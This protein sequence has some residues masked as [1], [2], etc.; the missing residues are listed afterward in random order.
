MIL[1]L[2]GRRS[3]SKVAVLYGAVAADAGPDEQD[4]L[5]EVETVSRGL[6]GLGYAP[7]AIPI[8]LDLEA[9][10]Q[11]LMH[12][13]PAFVFN[14]VESIEGQ[15]RLIHLAPALL[16]SLGLPHT[17]GSGDAAYVT[18]NKPLAKRLLAAAGISTPAWTA[19]GRLPDFP[20]PYI[21]KSVWEHASIGIEDGSVTSDPARLPGLLR[22]RQRRY[23]GEWFVE[24]YVEGREFNLSLLAGPDGVELLPPAE[25]CFVDYPPGKPRIV[26]YAAKWDAASFEYHATQRRFDFA[27]EE[28]TL[29]DNLTAT[30]KAC[31]RLFDLNGYARV[32]C[33][34][35]A[36][37]RV[38]VLEINMN[39]CISPDA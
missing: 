31:W 15:G 32:D 18:S 9:A 3:A 38:Q 5:T 6:A 23:G 10:R 21:V 14:L 13:R 33:R 22:K 11:R 7:V 28:R 26:N 34:V 1:P 36:A 12:L 17:G 37:G 20:G 27:P 35:D 39:P 4:V 25:M 30:A 19:P 16:E 29:I 24:A 2:K 8:T